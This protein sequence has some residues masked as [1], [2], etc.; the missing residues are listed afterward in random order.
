MR[1]VALSALLG[2]FALACAEE[3]ITE[4]PDAT[5]D[6]VPS[7]TEEVQHPMHLGITPPPALQDS[8]VLL[9]KRAAGDNIIGFFSYSNSC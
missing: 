6:E 4:K 5:P 7:R 2:V 9:D 1:L 8:M 3:L